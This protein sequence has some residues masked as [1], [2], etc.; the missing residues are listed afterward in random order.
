MKQGLLYVLLLWQFLPALAQRNSVQ[1]PEPP[2]QL[3][4]FALR[5]TLRKVYNRNA[6][7][8]SYD[9]ARRR[10]F[11]YVDNNSSGPKA[12]KVYCIYGGAFRNH[13]YGVSATSLDNASFNTEHIV[14][15]SFLT[16]TNSTKAKAD[17]HHLFPTFFVWNSTRSNHPFGEIS[18]AQ[19][20]SWQYL[21]EDANTWQP[22]NATEENAASR[23]RDM[24]G[25]I[26]MYMPKADK[27]GDVARAIMY[28]YTMYPDATP[29]HPITS[30]I[31]LQTMVNWHNADP[32]DAEELTRND[33]I[34]TYQNTRNPYVDW[35]EMAGRAFGVANCSTTPSV[36]VSGLSVSNLTANS[37]TLNWSSGNGDRRLISI[38]P[39]V[40]GTFSPTNGTTYTGI[41]SRYNLATVQGGAVRFVYLGAG[42][43]TTISG[44]DAGTA[45]TILAYE[46][47][48]SGPLYR[49]TSPAT[50]TATTLNCT[51]TPSL[52]ASALQAVVGSTST[53]NLSWARGNGNNV[54]LVARAGAAVNYVPPSGTAITGVNANFATATDKGSGNKIVYAGPADAVAVSGL[55]SG[56]TYH[57]R[58]Y[59]Y[60]SEGAGAPN[61]NTVTAPTR[62]ATTA[63]ACTSPV[64]VSTGLSSDFQTGGSISLVW[65]NGLGD[66]RIIIARKGGATSFLPANGTAPSGVNSDYAS[67]LNQGNDNRIVY[68]GTG[69]AVEVTGLEPNTTYFFTVVDYCLSGYV[70]ANISS[71]PTVS[72]STTVVN[73]V[74]ISCYL[75]GSGNNKAIEIYNGSGQEINLGTEGY[76]LRVFSN[77]NTTASI[78][79]FSNTAFVDAGQAFVVA[80]LNAASNI[81]SRARLLTGTLNF[82]GDDAVAL[83]KNNVL[84]DLVGNIG[85]L[86]GGNGWVAGTLRTNDMTLRRKTNSCTGIKA[87]PSGCTFPTLATDWV[88]F[89]TDDL[90]GLGAHNSVCSG[91]ATSITTGQ[92]ST[93]AYCVGGSGTTIEVPY[94]VDGEISAGNVYTLELSDATGAF[95]TAASIGTL[96]STALAGTVTGT[97]PAGL[98]PSVDYKVR[99][100]SSQPPAIGSTSASTLSISTAPGATSN[101]TAAVGNAQMTLNWALP[102][103]CYTSIMVVGRLG[104]G[105]VSAPAASASA[106]T[107]DASFGTTGTNANLNTAEFAVYKGTGSSVT[108]TNLSNGGLYYFRIYTNNGGTEWRNVAQVSGSPVAPA[109]GSTYR[110]RDVSPV[111]SSTGGAWS[112]ASHWEV[113][114]TSTGTWNT[115]GTAPD[116]TS[117]LITIRSGHR[118]NQTA[119][120]TIDQLVVEPNATLARVG[121]MSTR[122]ITV[123]DGIG[124]DIVIFGTLL[125]DATGTSSGFGTGIT[126][127]TNATMRIKNGAVVRILNNTGGGGDDYANNDAG[128]SGKII[129]ESTAKFLWALNSAPALSGQTFFPGAADSDFPSF[130][131]GVTIG[132]AVG[133]SNATTFRG[134]FSTAAG[135]SVTFSGTGQKH[136]VQGITGDG[137]M[138]QGSGTGKWVISG[139][140]ALLG[141]PTLVLSTN[142][143]EVAADATVTLVDNL[144][145]RGG[146]IVVNGT[147]D[148]GN[149]SIQDAS[150]GTYSIQVG[151]QG[152]IKTSNPAGVKASTGSLQGAGIHTLNNA[153]ATVEYYGDVSQFISPISYYNLVCTGAATKLFNGSTTVLNRVSLRAGTSVGASAPCT[154][155]LGGNLEADGTVLFNSSAHQL[156]SLELLNGAGHTFTTLGNTVRVAALFNPT[157]PTTYTGLTLSANSPLEVNGDL[158]LHIGTAYNL[159]LN[160]NTLGVGGSYL[161]SDAGASQTLNGT[162]ILRGKRSGTHTIGSRTTGIP[163][164]QWQHLVI[165]VEDA[166]ASYQLASA[167]TYTIPVA[168][169]MTV[170]RT[171]AGLY[172]GAQTRLEVAGDFIVLEPLASVEEV[173]CT[174]SGTRHFFYP[175]AELPKLVLEA[176][177]TSFQTMVSNP[178]KRYSWQEAFP[179]AN[180][181]V[182]LSKAATATVTATADAGTIVSGALVMDGGITWPASHTLYLQPGAAGGS[183]SGEG[184]AMYSL[185]RVL[186]MGGNTLSWSCANAEATSLLFE[187]GTLST[188][189][190]SAGGHSIQVQ[191]DITVE[192]GTTLTYTSGAPLLLQ[193]TGATAST[194]LAAPLPN[195]TPIYVAVQKSGSGVLRLGSDVVNARVTI[196]SGNLETNGHTLNLGA[197]G[198]LSGEAMGHEVIGTVMVS[199][200]L[201]QNDSSHFGGIGVVVDA[202]G[203]GATLGMVEVTRENTTT[204][205]AGKSSIGRRWLIEP[206]QQPSLGQQVA[207]RLT[208]TEGQLQ[209]QDYNTLSMW[210][211][212]TASTTWSKVVASKTRNAGA[213]TVTLSGTT[214]S[215]SYW[216]FSD[217]SNPLPVELLSWSGKHVPGFHELSW[218]VTQERDMSH[219][220]V[221]RSNDGMVWDSVATILALNNTGIQRYNHFVM[222]HAG[223]YYVLAMHDKDGTSKRSHMLYLGQSTSTDLKVGTLVQDYLVLSDLP[224]QNLQLRVFNAL[225]QE[226]SSVYTGGASNMDVPAAAWPTGLYWLEISAQGQPSQK[227]RLHKR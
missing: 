199:R 100:R 81:R 166:A 45:Y 193:A 227:F 117:D 56:T 123:N 150:G 182:N 190:S 111:N 62:S 156:L 208:T 103:S 188:L 2:S 129:W 42:T 112:T 203:S 220:T 201:A 67:A 176:G 133:G 153:G 17:I 53:I 192:A 195:G 11:A 104:T 16:G 71:C 211:R 170:L 206:A 39:T 105:V 218:N 137:T 121:D 58:M 122:R 68:N 210:R 43:T 204:T 94:A 152:V 214:G 209:G 97:L 4:G 135:T 6:T 183:F 32:P 79:G 194:L 110:S 134:V 212:P 164:I 106:Y 151:A 147:L 74:L 163:Q 77:G 125:V 55:S 87:D 128:F 91:A 173:V 46:V 225:G 120:L 155:S 184:S 92:L 30:V 119:N 20:S 21:E 168:G 179:I 200:T 198:W 115:A 222:A 221:L 118:I 141:G 83:Y 136:F 140:S 41:N 65:A 160:A 196:V 165:D 159:E 78:I 205:V 8:L 82:T 44:L 101:F 37:L 3:S 154:L 69:N 89:A 113:F 174:G 186:L 57:F 144:K 189:A 80:N 224:E 107:A 75:E 90:A 109:T 29:D 145:V 22:A 19:V 51:G 191:G 61:I 213:G 23:Y 49:L 114:N 95:T 157:A 59:E 50:T 108:I 88:G 169:S 84:L 207:L 161:L 38:R 131:V 102:S 5:D 66:A 18:N 7:I 197:E 85:C 178:L 64:G 138:T 181:V 10:M 127:G 124:D 202:A 187:S 130:E 9:N 126:F 226:M 52:Q 172:L 142:G 34:Q 25:A 12:N 1:F 167:G 139:S 180:R 158:N 73:E 215:F 162:V 143:L 54:L 223:A 98:A 216:T 27:R 149:F 33:R 86:P 31:S 48:S 35:P 70:Y 217:E 14:P 26:D 99:V 175:A 148:L 13:T 47:C 219:Y 15:Q 28:V 116:Q 93:T 96:P 40:G 146:P 36:Q 60:C 63:S 185:G 24:P 132:S 72:A 177:N 76:E 171:G